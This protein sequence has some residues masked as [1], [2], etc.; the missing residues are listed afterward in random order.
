M[1]TRC[2]VIALQN[3][4]RKDELR[5]LLWDCHTQFIRLCGF[6]SIPYNPE[7]KVAIVNKSFG[8]HM[9]IS[10][11]RGASLR[12]GEVLLELSVPNAWP[13][14]PCNK[15]LIDTFPALNFPFGSR[16]ETQRI[17]IHVSHIFDERI[18][19]SSYT[20][21]LAHTATRIH[22]SPTPISIFPSMPC[23]PEASKAHPHAQFLPT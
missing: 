18:C 22:D 11:D 9:N 21:E 8:T 15:V 4:W 6:Q 5:N 2:T 10:R 20:E 13:V 23:W 19:Q 17:L 7:S 1:T 14:G 3:D 12:A 16:G